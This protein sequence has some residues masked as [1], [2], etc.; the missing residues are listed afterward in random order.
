MAGRKE[1]RAVF[2][3][4]WFIGLRGKVYEWRAVVFGGRE[5]N[6]VFK[7]DVKM[8]MAG[9]EFPET[10][11]PVAGPVGIP[12]VPA[13]S[14]QRGKDF[15]KEKKITSIGFTA[16]KPEGVSVIDFDPQHGTPNLR[17][18]WETR[19]EDGQQYLY[20]DVQ[21]YPTQ[22]GARDPE[23]QLLSQREGTWRDAVD[24]AK[25]ISKG[26]TAGFKDKWSKAKGLGYEFTGTHRDKPYTERGWIVSYKKYTYWIRVQ[27]GGEDAEK[28]FSKLFK[29]LK[30]SVRF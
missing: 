8:L 28:A 5:A 15:D 12:S 17:L 9:I 1:N 11:E 21:S 18:A 19:S 2:V 25:I 26:K 10:L 30:K 13:F 7:Q 29:K 23:G 20:F 24:G 27:Y 22:P 4:Y 16:T 3:W 6:D 14:E